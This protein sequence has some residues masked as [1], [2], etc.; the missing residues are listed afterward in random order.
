LIHSEKIVDK[1][2]IPDDTSGANYEVVLDIQI[3]AA[4]APR[5]TILVYFA[6]N[7]DS[8]FYNAI[9]AAINNTEYR[10]SI[11]SISWGWYNSKFIKK[12]YKLTEFIYLKIENLNYLMN[13]YII[14]L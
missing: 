7:S 5:A 11:I 12:I 13:Y 3:A 8:G 10:P 9:A 2:S 6:P 4:I 1:Y 14:I